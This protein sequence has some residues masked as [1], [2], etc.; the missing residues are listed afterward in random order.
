M[1]TR[2][3]RADPAA[4][5]AACDPRTTFVLAGSAALDA[6]QAGMVHALFERGIAPDLLIGTSAGALNAA[7][8]AAGAGVPG[9]PVTLR[10]AACGRTAGTAAGW[11]P[12]TGVTAGE[13]SPARRTISRSRNGHHRGGRTLP[14]RR[15]GRRGRA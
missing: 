15:M 13:Q 6:M 11:G 8:P 7:P 10:G 9:W 5:R 1:S 14:P 2:T 12:V 3:L 4:G